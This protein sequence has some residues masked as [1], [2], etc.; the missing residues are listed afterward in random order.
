[1]PK[2]KAHAAAESALPPDLRDPF[3]ILVEDYKTAAEAHT[4]QKWVNYKILADLIRSGWR[5]A[6]SSN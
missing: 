3:N 4:G 6:Q 5:K 1:M 2:T